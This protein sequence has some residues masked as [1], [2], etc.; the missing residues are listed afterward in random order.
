MVAEICNPEKFQMLSR[1]C[2]H[3]VL[4]ISNEQIAAR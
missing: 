2:C 1:S 3:I 4:D